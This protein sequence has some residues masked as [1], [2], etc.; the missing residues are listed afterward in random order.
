[1]TKNADASDKNSGVEK[2]QNDAEKGKTRNGTTIK[3]FS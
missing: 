2:E 3:L 1:M